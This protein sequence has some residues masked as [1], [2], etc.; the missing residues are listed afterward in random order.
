LAAGV[1]AYS[2]A[3][4]GTGWFE[5]GVCI[6]IGFPLFLLWVFSGA[7]GFVRWREPEVIQIGKDYWHFQIA[8]H[9]GLFKR[10]SWRRT[11]TRIPA[12]DIEAILVYQTYSPSTGA[13]WAR[14][15]SGLHILI[16]HMSIDEARALQG[17][18]GGTGL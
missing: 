4:S 3:I 9:A 16:A 13:V 8:P 11:D 6:V 12:S 7:L 15:R 5:A 1:T 2:A 18:L 14:H 17:Q 10:M